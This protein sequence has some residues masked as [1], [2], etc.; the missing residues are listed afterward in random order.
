MTRVR[1]FT[2]AAFTWADLLGGSLGATQVYVMYFPSR[3][4]LPVDAEAEE[5]LRVFG[6]ATSGK[7]G[8]AFWDPRDEN[9][10]EALALFDLH[11]P[12]ALVVATGLVSDDGSLTDASDSI[13]CISFS[14]QTMLSDRARLAAAVNVAHEVLMRCDRREIARYIRGRKLRALLDL[15]SRGVGSVRDDLVELHPKFGLPGGFSLEIGGAA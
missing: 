9:F 10:G 4:D 5:S 11:N 15:I 1:S 3:F 14:D 12:P 8:V 6:D 2:S 7:T 13:Y